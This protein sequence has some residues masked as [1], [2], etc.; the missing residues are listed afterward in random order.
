MTAVP[1]HSAAAPRIAAGPVRPRTL[2]V[3]V[4][5]GVSRYLPRTLRALATQAH[6]PEVVV[7]I[8]VAGPGRDVG[9]G[10]PIHDAVIDAGL[11]E[12]TRVRVVRT[13]EAQNFGTAVGEGLREY[14]QLVARAAE[15]ARRREERGVENSSDAPLTGE[16][17][18]VTTGEIRAVGAAD[19]PAS[20]GS[21]PEWLWLLHD[22]SAP[23]PGALDHLL[24]AV[25]SGRS[26]AVAGPKQRGWDDP[27]R[28]LEVGI[29][30]TRTARRLPEIEPG[31]IDQGQHDHREDVLAVGT[32]GAL[33]RRSVWEEFDGTD[34]ALGPFGDGLELSR[35]ARLAGHRVV[36]VPAAVIH[37]AQ[38]SLLGQR[39][40]NPEETASEPPGP[41]L[42]RSFLA[43]RRA[44]IYNA[45]LA[46]PALAAPLLLLGY[47]FLGTARALWRVA[48]KE[49]GMAGGEIAAP[50]AVLGQTVSLVRA[51]RRIKRRLRPAA[52]APLEARG[53]QLRHARRDLRRTQATAQQRRVAPSE[54]EIA[55]RAALARRRRIGAGV[56]ALG[57][58]G[59]A[60]AAFGSLLTAGPLTSQPAG[61][62]ADGLAAGQG[63]LLP[64]DLSGS[65][66][67][68]LARSGW[69][70]AGIGAPGP[71]DAFWQ[72]LALP[73][74]L[75]LSVNHLVTAL[76][77]FAVP[78]A[79]IGAW[80]AAGA[81]ARAVSLRA[82]AALSWALAPA[83]LLAAGHGRLGPL[84]A[85]IALPWVLLGLARALGVERRDRTHTGIGTVTSLSGSRAG[86]VASGAGAALALAVA[87][88][89]AP[90]LLPAAL[91]AAVVLWPLLPIR[92]RGWIPFAITLPA[93]AVLGPLLQE[94]ASGVAAGTWRMLLAGGLPAPAPAAAPL[95]VLL[96]W[97]TAPIVVPVSEAGGTLGWLSEHALLIGG[98]TLGI[99]AILALL[100][101]TARARAVRAGWLVVLIGLAA[102]LLAQRTEAGLAPAGD[103]AVAAVS[104]WA[105]PGTSLIVLGLLIAVLSGGEGLYR[106]L[107]TRSFGWT[108]VAAGVLGL[109]LFAGPLLTGA[110]W[111]WAVHASAEDQPPAA[112]E[113]TAAVAV[114]GRE[115]APVP[116]IAR[117]YQDSGTRARVL[118][119]RPD[120]DGVQAEVWRYSGRQ[121]IEESA[122]RAVTD[123]IAQPT[124]EN[125]ENVENA[126]NEPAGQAGTQ[127]NAELQQAVASVAAGG[128]VDA[129]TVLGRHA[130]GVVVLPPGV[131]DDRDARAALANRLDVEGL[132]Y[133]TENAAGAFWRVPVAAG[134]GSVA[135]ARILDADGVVD[136]D[137]PAGQVGVEAEVPAGESGRRV[138]LAE[139]ADGHWRAW[140]DDEPLRSLAYGGQQ[141]FALPPEA[142]ALSIEYAAPWS[143]A[144]SA[145]Q[146]IVLALTALLA[147]PLRRR[148]GRAVTEEPEDA[149]PDHGLA[150]DAE[151]AEAHDGE[152]EPADRAAPA[153]STREGL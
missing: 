135:R 52:L 150:E 113:R 64:T 68:E 10:V 137:L 77:V 62:G 50:L 80:F 99:G 30:A 27:D 20:A 23:A 78:L 151:G 46:A 74:L 4:T 98:A 18:P 12:V 36:V 38:A 139:P 42:R 102:S 7:I 93:L 112:A 57:L 61:S 143:R 19:G 108:Q 153:E 21:E 89:G 35:R 105:G 58:T 31:E 123:L 15:R 101:G 148:P 100:R 132:E 17:S 22:D 45:A 5:A 119:L 85:H 117:Q 91:V 63:T 56:T 47:L 145:A 55:E 144:W 67:W 54:L 65:V 3:V 34:P 14:H 152:D 28:L 114:E 6:A 1:R 26:I 128:E 107:A 79:G 95:E 66:L 60:L 134:A 84:L 103:G 110:G 142:G 49:I 121:G 130:I 115:G 120:G 59:V 116:A 48:T 127:L 86:R 118:A 37:H 138:V 8:D 71:A 136:T 87:C 2:A 94:A 147:L 133:V 146:G 126:E 97:P 39:P 88:A 73:A 16:V 40:A 96:G 82:L 29:T 13:P 11:G 51:R 33:V 76:I 90:V 104:A 111:L 109:L 131:P 129:A 43:R 69:H 25:E 122:A 70:S 81:A 72:I 92:R 106:E 124:E 125:S 44:Q 149:E 141:A 9:T 53:A 24:R 75:G 41:D 32:A 83:V 140:Y